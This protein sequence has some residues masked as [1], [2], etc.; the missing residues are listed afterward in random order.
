MDCREFRD[1]HVDYTDGTCLEAERVAA[2]A[3]LG[4]CP[5]CA[6]FDLVIRRGLLVA[7]NLPSVP[8]TPRFQA[9]LTLRIARERGAVRPA[10]TAASW[11]RQAVTAAA[12]VLAAGALGGA[13]RLVAERVPF[14]SAPIAIDAVIRSSGP[15]IARLMTARVRARPGI[16]TAAELTPPWSATT[17]LDRTPVRFADAQQPAF[18]L[19]PA[20]R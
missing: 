11:R 13:T 6:R 16:M 1:R 15:E 12:A 18:W 2:Q 7:R 9:A 4:A 8:A 10:A 14:T 3:H 17:P 19:P 20:T 5:S